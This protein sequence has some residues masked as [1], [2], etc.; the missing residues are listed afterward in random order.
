MSP[1]QCA[2]AIV[3]GVLRNQL[4]VVVPSYI[5]WYAEFARLV[6]YKVSHL[7]RDYLGQERELAAFARAR[8]NTVFK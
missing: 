6:P 7:C 5:R 4:H 1:K 8:S 2:D 3:D